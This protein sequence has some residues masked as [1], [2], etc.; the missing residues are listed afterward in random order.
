MIEHKRILIVD[1]DERVLLIMRATLENLRNGT[2]V[3]TAG[4]GKEALAKIKEEPFDLVISDI[5]MPGMG[6]VELV[7][8]IRELG[9]HTSVIWITAY[10]YDKLEADRERLD[11]SLCL[12]KPL[13]IEKI[14]QAA[15]EALE[16]TM[17]DP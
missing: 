2:V 5:R 11:V 3:A 15:L 14:R 17:S 6:G 13:R 4:N 8:A 1:D 12:E 10:G 7:E 16:M 9:M